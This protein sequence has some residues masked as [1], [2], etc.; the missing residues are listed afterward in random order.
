MY[1]ELFISRTS[2]TRILL[3]RYF[4]VASAAF[5]VDFGSLIILKEIFNFN[6][7]VAATLSF[8]L[9]V[10]VNFY[11]STRWIFLDPKFS[12]KQYEFTGVALVALVGL[13]LNDL[14]LWFLTSQVGLYY[15]Y[16]KLFATGVIFFWNFFVRKKLLYTDN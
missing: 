1:R 10:I 14:I 7:L 8:C 4:F 15:I 12:K 16:S 13:L 11:L 2:E 6:Y 5:A 3:F 9:G